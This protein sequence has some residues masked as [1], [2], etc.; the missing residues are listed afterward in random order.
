MPTDEKNTKLKMLTIKK[1]CTIQYK[2]MLIQSILR[3]N[4]YGEI[5]IK[6]DSDLIHVFMVRVTQYKILRV[7]LNII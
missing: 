4:I 3:S 5:D 2:I 7:R 6:S 1:L